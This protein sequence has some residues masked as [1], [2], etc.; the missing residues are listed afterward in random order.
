MVPP[1]T[2]EVPVTPPPPQTELEKLGE[3]GNYARELTAKHNTSNQFEDIVKQGEDVADAN[4]NKEIE[5][6]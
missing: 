6:K 5:Q 4:R 3:A 1:I 2:P